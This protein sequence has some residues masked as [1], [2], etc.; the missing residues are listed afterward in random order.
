MVIALILYCRSPARQR[1]PVAAAQARCGGSAPKRRRRRRYCA[2]LSCYLIGFSGF[3]SLVYENAWTRALTLVI[4]SSIYSF[5]T[6]LVTFLIGLALRR[7][8]LRPFS[9]GAGG[10]PEH[11]R[12]DR[13]L[14]SAWPRWRRSLFR[15]AA[16]DFRSI[17][18][19]FW[20]H[21]YGVSLP[22][23]V[24]VGAG[25][26]R[27]HGAL[28]HDVSI[29]RAV[30]HPKPV[31]CRQRCGLLRRQYRRRS[32]RRLCRRLYLIPNIGVQNTIIFA[33]V[34]N[35]LIGCVARVERSANASCRDT[36]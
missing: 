22:A 17:A 24:S 9:R 11:L 26:V 29:G 10:P 2:G 27:A 6:M 35:L 8:Y 30:V 36:R 34:M 14:W 19:R 5:T 12:A 1:T 28:G 16:S 21:V 3:A 13:A 7:L 25:D 23:N 15:T 20:R 18:A 4:G 32:P 31:S 33:V